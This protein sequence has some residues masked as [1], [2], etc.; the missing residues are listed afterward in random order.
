MIH[1]LDGVRV[2]DCAVPSNGDRTGRI[3]GDL[4]GGGV[5]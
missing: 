1:L 4:G 2:L 3:L 5:G